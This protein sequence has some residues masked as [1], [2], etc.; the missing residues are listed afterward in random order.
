[1]FKVLFDR[2]GW[3]GWEEVQRAGVQYTLDT[4]V[5]ELYYN[6]ERKLDIFW[7]L[8]FTVR[9]RN[10]FRIWRRHYLSNIFSIWCCLKTNSLTNRLKINWL[11]EFG[12]STLHSFCVSCSLD[13]L[14]SKL[15]PNCRLYIPLYYGFHNNLNRDMGQTVNNVVLI[16]FL[17]RK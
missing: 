9:P 16:L 1:M 10:L 13:C 6:P 4:V 3:Y 12:L 7:F 8:N 14:K 5:T 17:L 15:E 11:S 2:D